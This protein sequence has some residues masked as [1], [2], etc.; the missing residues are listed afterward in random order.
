MMTAFDRYKASS[1]A[2]YNFKLPER[3][4]SSL[5]TR[6]CGVSRMDDTVMEELGADIQSLSILDV[7][8]ATGRLLSRLARAGATKLAGTDLAPRI[9]DVARVK[10]KGLSTEAELKAADCEEHLPWDSATFDVV[11]MTGVLHHFYR[12][13]P[14]LS[15]VCRVLKPGGRLILVDPCF[16]TPVRYIFNIWL[17]F[18]PHDGDYRF[19]T[20]TEAQRLFDNDTWPHVKAKR[21]DWCYFSVLAVRSD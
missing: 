17:R 16:F 6:L 14:A 21:L 10:L 2:A 7:G 15:E 8:C 5:I 9:L 11:T 18:H 3:Y 20:P 12:P 4:D 13:Q 19:Y 1:Y